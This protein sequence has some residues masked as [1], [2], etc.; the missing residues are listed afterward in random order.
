MYKIQTK[1]P[2]FRMFTAY[3]RLKITLDYPFLHQFRA[4]NGH[5]L[6]TNCA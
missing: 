1:N 6:G 2:R 4:Q 5:F 3:D